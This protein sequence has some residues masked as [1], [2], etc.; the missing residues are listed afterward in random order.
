MQSLDP[1]S[2]RNFPQRRLWAR[3]TREPGRSMGESFQV[4]VIETRLAVV[5]YCC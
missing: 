3:F 4:A 1:P 5:R 2:S